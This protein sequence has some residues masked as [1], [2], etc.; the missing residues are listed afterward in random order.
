LKAFYVIAFLLHFFVLLTVSCQ[1][2][3]WI[4][5]NGYT[6]L[7]SSLQKYWR[8]A[9]AVSGV[10]LGQGLD[11][12]N[13]LRQT[14][15]SY[16]QSAGIEGGYGFFAPGVPNSYKLVFELHYDDRRIEYD[17]PHVRDV[18]T[19]LR[20]S[21]LLDE[22]GRTSYEPLRELMVKM[23]AYAMWQEHPDAVAIR[24]VFGYV[25]TPSAAELREGKHETYNFLYA[26]DFS[27][28]GQSAP[29]QTR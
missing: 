5:A 18:E 21:S 23:L 2:T 4:L 19:G 8:K 16:V 15:N 24:A 20:L 3:F 29:K 28:A 12:S 22:I 10:A 14:M 17:L 9:E 25:E 13:P 11:L 6:S 26:Y 27:F 1:Q 7:P